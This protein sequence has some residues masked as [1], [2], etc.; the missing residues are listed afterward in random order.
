MDLSVQQCWWWC[1]AALLLPANL[2]LHHWPLA[3]KSM[4]VL[5]ARQTLTSSGVLTGGRHC[6]PQICL[7][8]LL[9][10]QLLLDCSL[11]PLLRMLGQLMLMLGSA[12]LGNL[13]LVHNEAPLHQ[14]HIVQLAGAPCSHVAMCQLPVYCQ[15]A[16]AFRQQCGHRP[17][18]AY[19]SSA[20]AVRQ[21]SGDLSAAARC[22]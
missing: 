12:S 19:C 3:P 20:A 2:E 22:P 7:R 11:T 17:P 9:G 14:P 16:A 8:S 4:H 18:A 6:R 15:S 21:W 13:C 10:N 1:F 5:E